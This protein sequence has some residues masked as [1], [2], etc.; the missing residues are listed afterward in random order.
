MTATKRP[1]AI[2]PTRLP[3]P[4]PPPISDSQPLQVPSSH[5][6][7]GMGV[8]TMRQGGLWRAKSYAAMVRDVQRWCDTSLPDVSAVCGIPRS[9]VCPASIVAA[10]RNIPLISFDAML[11]GEWESYR[12]DSGRH[13]NH[14]HGPILML[15]DSTATG[16]ALEHHI[17]KLGERPGLI[18]GSVYVTEHGAR[19]VDCFWEVVSDFH[20]FEWITVRDAFVDIEM[21]DLDGVICEEP[22]MPDFETPR[23]VNPE[24]LSWIETAPTKFRPM[25]EV[26]T[27]CTARLEQFRPETE[28]WL[29]YRGIK[30]RR[31]LMHPAKTAKARD[32]QGH[33][34]YK[35]EHFDRSDC[36]LFIE[37]CPMQAAAIHEL[38]GKTTLCP[39]P[40]LMWQNNEPVDP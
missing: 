7:P 15:D 39:D 1:P 14:P 24:W 38:T 37:S 19:M 36:K 9:G 21:L 27:I 12:F 35:A 25:F 32:R 22:P 4:S 34:K 6:Y 31:L 17:E 13:I 10:H 16:R 18:Y 2:Q 26:N 29:E 33:A 23:K 11:L 3:L 28:R 5:W 40:F 20:Q 8:P 30:C